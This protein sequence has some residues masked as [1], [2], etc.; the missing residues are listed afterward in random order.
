MASLEFVG[1]LAQ[2]GAGV[3]VVAAVALGPGVAGDR[4]ASH[5]ERRHPVGQGFVRVGEQLAQRG[6][7]RLG[8][9]PQILVD[10]LHDAFLRRLLADLGA[11]IVSNT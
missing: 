8:S 5:D 7:L 3:G 4:L 10:R 9:C 6:P 11:T 1:E 2:H